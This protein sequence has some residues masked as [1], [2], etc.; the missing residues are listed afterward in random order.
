[1]FPA[2]ISH[3]AKWLRTRRCSNPIFR[4]SQSTNKW[5]KKTLFRD[6]PTFSR[7]C[8]FS[9][10]TFYMSELLHVWSSHFWLP[11]CLSFFLA[12]LFH[13]SILSEVLFL[14][15][16]WALLNNQISFLSLSGPQCVVAVVFQ[17]HNTTKQDMFFQKAWGKL[18]G[19]RERNLKQA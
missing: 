7:T 5:K 14:N 17:E 4:P 18:G 2:Q 3:L 15:F 13:L 12:V 10:L 11:P 1:M 9:L 16:L 8:I 6:F 19:E